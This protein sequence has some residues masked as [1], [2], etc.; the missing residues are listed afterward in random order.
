MTTK[1][2]F[3]LLQACYWCTYASFNSYVGNFLQSEGMSA[4]VLGLL[5]TTFTFM[6]FLGNFVFGYICD[7]FKTNKKVL[8]FCYVLTAIFITLTYFSTNWVMVIAFYGCLGF[9]QQPMVA[10]LDTW[11]LRNYSKEPK[12]YGPIRSFASVA[13]C[14]LNFFYGDLLGEYGYI[15]MIFFSYFFVTLGI[16]VASL[17]F[18]VPFEDKVEEN[19]LKVSEAFKI[20][21]RSKPYMALLIIMLGMGFINTPIGSLSTIIVT[22]V[23]GGVEE[24]ATLL[25]FSSMS[26]IPM[27]FFSYKL[28]F[29]PPKVRL[30][31]CGFLFAISGFGMAFATN[32]VQIVIFGCLGGGVGTGILVPTVREMV[33][34]VSPKECLTSA[35]SLSDSV[36]YSLS[37]IV[38]SALAGLSFANFGV[39]ITLVTFAS[40]TVLTILAFLFIMHL[41]K[42]ESL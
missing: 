4:S 8:I 24:L 21:F 14:S 38:A 29:I 27:L 40:F 19:G 9:V 16:I 28:I 34:L 41:A 39:T 22:N 37:G 32:I 11:I 31:I 10:N 3:A 7:K 18:E 5:I 25:V 35:Q 2:K 12:A 33:V 20:L 13:F 6:G 1:I 42:K 15:L 26:Q 30:L 36:F 17:T 23:G